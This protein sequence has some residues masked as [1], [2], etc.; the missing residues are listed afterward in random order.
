MFKKECYFKIQL[1]PLL[2]L[3]LSYTNIFFVFN[4]LI[5]YIFNSPNVQIFKKE[6]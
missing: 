2:N 5:N 6:Y 1:L 3:I 4:K